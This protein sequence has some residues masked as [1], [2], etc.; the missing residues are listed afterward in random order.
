MPARTS[1]RNI[2]AW[3]PELGARETS[4]QEKEKVTHDLKGRRILV[5]GSSTGIGAA[6]AQAYAQAGAEVT[7][8]YNQSRAQAEA[9]VA[10]IRAAGGTGHIV[11][12][13]V[14]QST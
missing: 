14:S 11:G 13:D 10:S 12:G 1:P 7:V 5:T 6:V 3:P 9:V 2:P 8:H 4:H